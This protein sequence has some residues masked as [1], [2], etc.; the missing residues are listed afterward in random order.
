MCDFVTSLTNDNKEKRNIKDIFRGQIGIIDF[1]L[2]T[3]DSNSIKKLENHKNKK[4]GQLSLTAKKAQN[5]DEYPEEIFYSVDF[6]DLKLNND[7]PDDIVFQTLIIQRKYLLP[8]REELLEKWENKIKKLIRVKTELQHEVDKGCEPKELL[9]IYNYKS[10]AHT[11]FSD[12]PKVGEIVTVQEVL[13]G[14][15]DS[16]LNEPI[17]W[18]GQIG[19]ILA[20][21]E[22]KKVEVLFLDKNMRELLYYSTNAQEISEDLKKI[23]NDEAEREFHREIRIKIEKKFL[24]PLYAEELQLSATSEQKDLREELIKNEMINKHVERIVYNIIK[25]N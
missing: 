6:I 3:V 24:L 17:V 19:I 20:L 13:Y 9:D 23:Y 22:K 10:L 25:T 2:M 7:Y 4:G 15:T 5:P 1:A 11:K 21:C 16:A 14:N 8:L 12:F 18:P